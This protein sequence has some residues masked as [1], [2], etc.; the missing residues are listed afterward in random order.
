MHVVYS[1][2]YSN[3]IVFIMN[4]ET[5]KGIDMDDK[6]TRYTEAQARAIK[7]HNSEL[8][9]IG[10]YL[11]KGKKEQYQAAAAALGLSMNQ[12][13]MAAMDDKIKH[14]LHDLI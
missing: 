14:D 11:P 9:R 1:V 8:D 13:A 10:L 4:H 3:M 5:T 12:F 2:I 7:K 6:K